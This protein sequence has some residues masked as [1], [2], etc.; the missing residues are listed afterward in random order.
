MAIASAIAIFV[1]SCSGKLREANDINLDEVPLQTIRDMFAVDT[2]NGL[3]TMR[4]EAD[5][6][7][8][9]ETDTTSYESFPEGFMVYGYTDEGLLET[10]IESDDARHITFK[11]GDRKEIWEAF[12]NVVIHNIIKQETMET[13]TIYWDR[14][15]AEIYTDCYVRMYSPDGFMQGYGMRSDDRARNAI[16]LKPFNGFV[17][18][19]QDT[20]AVVIDSVNFIGPLLKK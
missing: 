11:T 19:V 9:Y 10:L 14:T 4:V 20:T 15:A 1:V 16:L 18:T 3:V 7:E 6:M 13:D 2:Q 12:G 5:L 17:Y 8:K